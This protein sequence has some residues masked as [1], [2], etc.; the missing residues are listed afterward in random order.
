MGEY[1]P[2]DSRKVTQTD[3]RA[4]GEQPRTGPREDEARRKAQDDKDIEAKRMPQQQQRAQ[5]SQSGGGQSQSQSQS[6]AR[7]SQSEPGQKDEGAA[8]ASSAPGNADD[9]RAMQA[10]PGGALAGNQPQAIDNQAGS[11]RPQYDQY[12]VNQPQ[13]MHQSNP[14]EQDRLRQQAGMQDGGDRGFGYGADGET[15]MKDAPNQTDAELQAV[16]DEEAGEPDAEMRGYGGRGEMA[17]DGNE[18]R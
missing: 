13:N 18:K 16:S 15:E 11:A 14:A 12:E 17:Q 4:P 2:D 1:E 3:N 6:G 7:Q 9:E 8:A 10:N 5:Q